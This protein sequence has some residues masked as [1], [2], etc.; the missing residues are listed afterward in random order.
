M[1]IFGRAEVCRSDENR[2]GQDLTK[3]DDEPA[4]PALPEPGVLRELAGDSGRDND[5][6]AA[7]G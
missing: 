7:G 2:E 1:P 3:A 6:L 4:V 5:H